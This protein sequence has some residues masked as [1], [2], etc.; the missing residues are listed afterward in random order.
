M[1]LPFIKVCMVTIRT[2]TRPFNVV[3]SRRMRYQA[4]EYEKEFFYKVGMATFKLE[5]KID[6]QFN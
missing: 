5:N 3:L 1:P 2:F 4:S 6:E